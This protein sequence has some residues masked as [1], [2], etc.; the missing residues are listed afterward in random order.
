MKSAAETEFAETEKKAARFLAKDAWKLQ[1]RRAAP[2]LLPR[3]PAREP[4][5]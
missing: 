4:E 2:P 5:R 1:V 3:L